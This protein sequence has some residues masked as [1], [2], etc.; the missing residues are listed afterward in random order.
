MRRTRR[1][2]FPHGQIP[3]YVLR[4]C[5]AP[6]VLAPIV[7]ASLPTTRS[8]P[9]NHNHSW[10]GHWYIMTQLSYHTYTS[11]DTTTLPVLCRLRISPVTGRTLSDSCAGVSGEQSAKVPILF[12]TTIISCTNSLSG[13]G[14]TC[15][16]YNCAS[17]RTH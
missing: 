13:I 3:L 4:L 17:N 6:I 1:N 10:A 14:K 7:L 12:Y 9:T 2:H 11:F 5:K 16:L 8:I 15:Y